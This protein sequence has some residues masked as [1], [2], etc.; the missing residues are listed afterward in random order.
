MGAVT[1]PAECLRGAR[2][3]ANAVTTGTGRGENTV[4]FVRTSCDAATIVGHGNLRHYRMAAG[5]A[6]QMPQDLR[7]FV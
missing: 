4:I 5:N 7:Q 6:E 1:S 2:K 3:C